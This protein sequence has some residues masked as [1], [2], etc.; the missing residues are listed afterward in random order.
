M[1][2]FGAVLTCV[3]GRIQRKVSDYLLTVFGVRNLDTITAAGMIR[4]IAA[5][6][7]RSSDLLGDLDVSVAQ[8]GSQDIAVVAHH[9]CAGNPTSDKVQ[10]DQILEAMARVSKRH[11]DAEVVGL[12]VDRNWTVERI[13]ARDASL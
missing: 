3:D 11:P 10:R 6:T 1:R 4:H 13:R 7:E 12:W 5:E 2:E 9:D 8:H